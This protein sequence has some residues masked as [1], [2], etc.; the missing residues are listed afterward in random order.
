LHKPTNWNK[1]NDDRDK[2][3][4]QAADF[5][6]ICEYNFFRCK[7]FSAITFFASLIHDL[8]AILS[9]YGFGNDIGIN[10]G[11]LGMA[12]TTTA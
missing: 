2:I 1:F 10:P 3:I 5:L 7:V 8:V 9:G 11:P 4:A 12:A 6:T